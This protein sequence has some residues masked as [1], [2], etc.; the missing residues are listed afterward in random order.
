MTE[1]LE[2]RRY[3]KDSYWKST[4]EQSDNESSSRLEDT[5]GQGHF[6][7]EGKLNFGFRKVPKDDGSRD[8]ESM[9]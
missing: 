1:Y 6:V 5:T 3:K 2:K 7:F 9:S 8:D 4:M